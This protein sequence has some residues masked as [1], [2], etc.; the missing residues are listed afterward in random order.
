M[1]R[2][3]SCSAS[4]RAAVAMYGV[5]L[6]CP[7]WRWAVHRHSGW[8]YRAGAAMGG[9]SPQRAWQPCRRGDGSDPPRRAGGG[10]CPLLRAGASSVPRVALARSTRA[11]Q[12]WHHGICLVV[13]HFQRQHDSAV[14]RRTPHARCLL[15]ARHQPHGKAPRPAVSGGSAHGPGGVLQRGGRVRRAE[16]EGVT[17]G[18][19]GAEKWPAETPHANNAARH[20]STA[21][22]HCHARTRTHYAADAD[23]PS[24][25]CGYDA[26]SASTR[27]EERRVLGDARAGERGARQRRSPRPPLS[28]RK[29]R[30]GGVSRGRRGAPPLP[31]PL[32]RA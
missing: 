2:C 12:W 11:A 22:P 4:A 21:A 30:A 6:P 32:P 7:L 16:G 13:P 26:L 14:A 28:H 15:H 17:R 5:G 24:P 20:S 1:G 8:A 27:R 29:R 23:A 19:S 25:E 18:G 31:T 10:A 9:P 3:G